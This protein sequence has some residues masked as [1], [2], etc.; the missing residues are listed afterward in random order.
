MRPRRPVTSPTSSWKM[1]RFGH[2]SSC[3]RQFFAEFPQ[4]VRRIPNHPLH[5]HPLQPLTPVWHN[6]RWQSNLRPWTT[7][8]RPPPC[9]HRKKH[10][11]IVGLHLHHRRRRRPL[12]HSRPALR[13]RSLLLSRHRSRSDRLRQLINRRVRAAG[14]H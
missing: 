5:P 11:R 1:I 10:R 8:G 6:L 2:A 14:C 3:R 13:Q 9:A 4:R 12:S 7:R